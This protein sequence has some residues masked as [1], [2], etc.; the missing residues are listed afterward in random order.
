M[1]A[2]VGREQDEG[3]VRLTLDNGEWGQSFTAA[4]W[5]RFGARLHSLAGRTGFVGEAAGLAAAEET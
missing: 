3:Q 4:L 2:E 5:H 1:V